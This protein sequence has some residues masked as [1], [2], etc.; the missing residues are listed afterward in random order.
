[1][2][3]IN[4]TQRLQ[5][6]DLITELELGISEFALEKDFMVTD[7]L[8]QIININN[9][10]F[11]L[12]FVEAHASPKPTTYWSE[13]LKTWILKRPQNLQER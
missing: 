12:I 10:D 13:S 6:L 9:P 8:A 2:K 11:D 3:K 4:D 1:M 7:A 5:V